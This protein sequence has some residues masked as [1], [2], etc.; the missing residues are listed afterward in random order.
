M[1]WRDRLLRG[2]FRGIPFAIQE[3][4]VEGGRRAQ[5]HEYPGRDEPYTED[6]GRRR[7]Q[8]EVEAYVIGDDYAAVRDDLIEAADK[9]GPGALVHPYLGTRQ[10]TCTKCAVS[11]RS[12][13]GRMARLSL[14]FVEAGRNIHP[15]DRADSAAVIDGAAA[16]ARQAAT[17]Q[18]LSAFGL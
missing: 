18:F 17:R 5:T 12:S 15:A 7:K 3:H 10:V 14:V 11:E 2:S 9:P 13:E 16:A 4:R 8:Y 1:A 6:L